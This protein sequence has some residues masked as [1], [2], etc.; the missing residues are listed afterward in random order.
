MSV[1]TNDLVE[2]VLEKFYEYERAGI[3]EYWLLDPQ[4]RRA[5]FY[6]LGSEGQYHLIAPDKDAR[7]RSAVLPGF[8]LQAS[9]LWQRPLPRMLDVLRELGVL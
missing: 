8:W 4:T 1:V 9:W 7:Y 2:Q 6:Q 3:P 5:E